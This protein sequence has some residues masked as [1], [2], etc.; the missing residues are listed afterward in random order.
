M[1]KFEGK[2]LLIDTNLLIAISKYSR[3]RFFDDFLEELETLKIRSVIDEATLFE[4]IRG[5][6][7]Q[8][9]LNDK[10][11]FLDFLLGGER[12]SL[13]IPKEVFLGA[14]KL[15]TIY[16]NKNQNLSKQI[17]FTDCLVASQLMKYKNNMYL[18]TIDNN[19]FPQFIFDRDKV[20]TI[21]TEKEIINIGIYSFNE[22][23]YKTCEENF[24]K[25]KI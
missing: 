8:N 10:N 2:H 16:S 13:P 17:S 6:K 20:V 22:E 21:D 3:L 14:Q 25:S 18:A 4:F 19:D 23:K 24:S 5:S 12:W 7:T 1:K 15:A 9:H 11:K